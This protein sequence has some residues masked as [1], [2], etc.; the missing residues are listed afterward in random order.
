MVLATKFSMD[1]RSHAIGKGP[2]AAN[3]AKTTHRP[4]YQTEEE[5]KL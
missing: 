2:Q 4:F 5:I 1:Y 3:F